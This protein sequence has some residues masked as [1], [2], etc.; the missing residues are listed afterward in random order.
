LNGEDGDDEGPHGGLFGDEGNDILDGGSGSDLL[1]GG[2]DDDT[3]SGGSGSGEDELIGGSGEDVL[4]GGGGSDRLH[5]G[6]DD[7]ELHGGLNGD[8][9]WGGTGNDALYGEEGDDELHGDNQFGP[10][11]I[12]GNDKLFGGPGKDQLYGQAGNDV[13]F[14]DAGEDILKGGEGNDYLNSQDEI[15]NNDQV[16]GDAGSDSCNTDPDPKQECELIKLASLIALLDIARPGQSNRMQLEMSQA[17][18]LSTIREWRVEEPDGDVCVDLSKAGVEVKGGG[19]VFSSF[20]GDY[21]ISR[22]DNRLTGDNECS[23]ESA[24]GIAPIFM[25]AVQVSVDPVDI[26][27]EET[28]ETFFTVT[29]TPQVLGRAILLGEKQDARLRNG[30]AFVGPVDGAIADDHGGEPLAGADD[31]VARQLVERQG[32]DEGSVGVED[33]SIAR[34]IRQGDG[35]VDGRRIA[36][37]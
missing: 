16:D 12:G 36:R 34:L 24:A 23:V 2:D 13:L 26:V 17:A 20:P 25:V 9:L 32:L 31:V 29:C 10:A 8:V 28:F 21:T 4:D 1:N 30:V 19:R 6:D 22:D 33:D 11:N 18:S 27:F 5:G 37:H 7:D 35:V 14:G 3:L 15:V